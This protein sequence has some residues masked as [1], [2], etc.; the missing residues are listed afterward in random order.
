MGG[1]DRRRNCD[2]PDLGAPYDAA[3]S[4]AI[5]YLYTIVDPTA[6]VV[7]GT[8]V[9]GNPDPSSD[10]DIFILHDEPW[11]QRVQRSFAGVPVEL[12]INHPDF[13][14][15]YFKEDRA[16]GKPTTAHM[17]A[18]GHLALDTAGV[19][20][21]FIAA[22]RQMLDAGPEVDDGRLTF[23]RY[24][25]AM[26]FEDAGDLLDRDPELATLLLHDAVASALRFC[27][28]REYRWQPRNKDLF[29]ELAEMDTDLVSLARRFHRTRS[30]AER[31]DLAREIVV[32]T[33]GEIGAFDWETPRDPLPDGGAS[34]D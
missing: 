29:S 3:L 21:G 28:W 16:R 26:L 9:R 30:V 34:A 17:L 25:T 15:A 1:S 31:Y 2:L 8:I 20:A 24:E 23:Q 18:T 12:F 6:I 10:L 33:T 32:K 19:M 22:S 14:A 4:A 7:A 5:D 11:R 13:M 27:F